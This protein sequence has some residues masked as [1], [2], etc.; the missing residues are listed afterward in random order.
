M[1]EQKNKNLSQK[2]SQQNEPFESDAAR[3]TSRHMEDPNHVFTDEEM[4]SIKVGVTPPPDEPTKEA[5][6]QGEDHIADHKADNEDDTTPGA[7]KSTPWDV[8]NP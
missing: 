2:E 1:N 3:L 8:I 7:Q 6:S 5:I 4:R